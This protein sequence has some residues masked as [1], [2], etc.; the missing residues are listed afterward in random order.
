MT[1]ALAFKSSLKMSCVLGAAALLALGALSV[2]QVATAGQRADTC[3]PVKTVHKAKTSKTKVLKTKAKAT[4]AKTI[5][6][7][8]KSK[9][10]TKVM[11]VAAGPC[12]CR[13]EVRVVKVIQPVIEREVVVYRAEPR[14]SRAPYVDE[15]ASDRYAA[16]EET[17]YAEAYHE[18]GTSYSEHQ[19]ERHIYSRS[20]REDYLAVDT[21]PGHHRDARYTSWIEQ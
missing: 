18:E 15:V 20:D 7:A 21:R 10:K 8:H 17:S 2:P 3:K 4:K 11:K 5:A 6:V 16:H 13:K 14:S 19:S 1:T 9:P 12:D